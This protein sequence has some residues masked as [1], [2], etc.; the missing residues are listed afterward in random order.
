MNIKEEINN[1]IRKIQIKKENFIKE[2]E[3]RYLIHKKEE[4]KINGR[5]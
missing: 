4:K 3:K 1:D 2:N 5:I